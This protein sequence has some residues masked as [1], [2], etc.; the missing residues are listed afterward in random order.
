MSERDRQK[1]Q[2]KYEQLKQLI[3]TPMMWQESE[4]NVELF[5][6]FGEGEGVG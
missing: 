5:G 3:V 1:A 6:V 2:Q 4:K